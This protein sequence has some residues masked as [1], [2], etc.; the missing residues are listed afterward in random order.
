MKFN[1]LE[2][3]ISKIGKE[4]TNALL[5]ELLKNDSIASGKLLNSVHPNISVDLEEILLL[6]SLPEYAEYVDT[7]TRPR[8]AGSGGF[9]QA[10]QKWVQEKGFPP[11]S[12]FPIARTIWT[13]GVKARPFLFKWEETLHIFGLNLDGQ[14]N[15]ENPF[16]QAV[17]RDFTEHL[18]IFINEKFNL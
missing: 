10:I 5:Q 11:Q 15:E 2:N 13:Q 6:I 9:T 16:K 17:E 7:G 3:L 18:N 8:T 4:A 1:H 12:A 14:L